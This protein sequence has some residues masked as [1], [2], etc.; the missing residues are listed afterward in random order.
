MCDHSH[1]SM[2]VPWILCKMNLIHPSGP[3]V[4]WDAT[5]YDATGVA[6]SPKK[7]IHGNGL[8]AYHLGTWMVMVN[9][10]KYTIHWS[11]RIVKWCMIRTYINNYQRN[12]VF[13]NDE[14]SWDPKTGGLEM[15][16]DPC[17]THPNP[18]R[19]LV[20]LR[21]VNQQDSGWFNSANLL[22]THTNTPWKQVRF[23]LNGVGES[24]RRCLQYLDSSLKIEALRK[25]RQLDSD[26]FHAKKRTRKFQLQGS[27][28]LI[29][30][31][32][33]QMVNVW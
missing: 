17:Y 33:S 10:G 12:Y 28:F 19:G 16:G 18:S 3:S 11:H 5:V 4:G 27:S 14:E 20:I 22:L 9:V 32:K 15:S 8:S 23:C 13:A 7:R 26:G 31:Y 6:C 21:A 24:C 29:P 30:P 25:G 2:S 1:E